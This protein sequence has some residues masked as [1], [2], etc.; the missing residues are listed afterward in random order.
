MIYSARKKTVGYK[1]HAMQTRQSKPSSLFR[2]KADDSIYDSET[3]VLEEASSSSA[4]S[5]RRPRSNSGSTD[6]LEEASSSSSSSRQYHSNSGDD[7]LSER[8]IQR[9]RGRHRSDP[10]RSYLV[11]VD[12]MPFRAQKKTRRRHSKE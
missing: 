11:P 6:V 1:R 4:V 7:D 10:V 5:S 12:P 2:D 3:D 9:A 8:D